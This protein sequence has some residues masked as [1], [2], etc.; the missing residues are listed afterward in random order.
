MKPVTIGIVGCGHIS[1]TY[2]RNAKL[3]QC[4]RVK[5]CA[6]LISERAKAKADR[7]GIHAASVEEIIADPDIEL[8]MNL[9]VPT[10]HYDLGRRIVGGAKHLYSEKP[11]CISVEQAKHL[12]DEAKRRN[13]RVGSAPDTFLGGGHQNARGLIDAGAIGRPIAGI[14]YVMSHGMEDWHPNPEFFFKPGGGPLLDMGVY[15]VAALVHLLGPA[16]RVS[17]SA[18]IHNCTRVVATGPLSGSR[19]HAEVPTTSFGVIDFANGAQVAVGASWD[20]WRHKH[21]CIEIFGTEGSMVLPDPN[22]FGGNVLVSHR[23]AEWEARRPNSYAFSEDNATDLGEQVADYRI[24]GVADLAYAIREQ[25]PHRIAE[26]FI[27]HVLEVME[28][29][30]QSSESGRHI[31]MLSTCARP[32]ALKRGQGEEALRI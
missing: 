3:F 22:F 18:S 20:I 13:V 28:A 16:R 27:L 17:A 9:T 26:D 2:L 30:Q 15:Y 12:L 6:D 23:G 10:A 21:A 19:I 5:S 24:V 11:F 1:E 7:H 25:R 8:V 14:A 29:F 32:P 4:L 31:N